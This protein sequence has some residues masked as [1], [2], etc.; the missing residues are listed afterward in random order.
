MASMSMRRMPEEK[1]LKVVRGYLRTAGETISA[2]RRE[3]AERYMQQQ[4]DVQQQEL[5][6]DHMAE[7]TTKK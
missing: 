3:R 6:A 1:K 2:E 4:F 5:E 7:G